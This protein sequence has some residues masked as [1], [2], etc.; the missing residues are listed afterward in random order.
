MFYQLTGLFCTCIA[1]NGKVIA[2]DELGSMR[3]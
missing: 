3:N 2:N 1:S